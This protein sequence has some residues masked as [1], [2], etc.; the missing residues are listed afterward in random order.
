M[1]KVRGD[2]DE[3]WIAHIL[4]VNVST[5]SCQV[6]FYAENGNIYKK[7][8]SRSESIH[9]NTV[10]GFLKVKWFLDHSFTILE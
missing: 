3:V 1:I 5:Q 2:N 8:S 7:E 10:L 6:N 9:W 4:S